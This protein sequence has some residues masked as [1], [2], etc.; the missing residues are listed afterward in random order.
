MTP[1]RREGKG[2]HVLGC[3]LRPPPARVGHFGFQGVDPSE[4]NWRISLRGSVADEK[5]SL[6]YPRRKDGRMPNRTLTFRMLPHSVRVHFQ[7]CNQP[8]KGG[9]LPHARSTSP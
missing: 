7:N 1:A 2:P 6:C 4:E 8:S 9:K 3:E 5:Q